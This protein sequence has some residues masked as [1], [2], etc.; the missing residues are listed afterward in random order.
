[1]NAY[2]HAFHCVS[3]QGITMALQQDVLQLLLLF[4]AV[5]CMWQMLVTVVVFFV[6]VTLP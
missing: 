6:M 2:C 1:M 3:M 4:W 5:T